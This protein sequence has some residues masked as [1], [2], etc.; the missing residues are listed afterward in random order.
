[1][2]NRS[3]RPPLVLLH[4][5]G[6]SPMA[7]EDVVPP[8]YA[9]RRLLTPW[10]PG[11]RPIDREILPLPEAAAALD[12]QLFLEGF[13]EV[14]ICAVSWGAMVALQLAADFPARVRR[15]IVIG[16]QVRP[17][18]VAIW[19]QRQAVRLVPASRLADDGV[20]KARLLDLLEVASR[21]DLRPVLSSITAATLVV[22]GSRDRVGAPAARLLA[23]TL[24]HARLV[25][26][27]GGGP[28]LN[29]QAPA[30]VV[31]LVRSHL[32]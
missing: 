1:M 13:E 18:R 14:D 29:T 30:T 24:P 3:A 5:L 8:L 19:A 21:A 17:P 27:P 2:V 7:W 15:L 25:I 26:M 31:E 22:V 10:V 11:T 4:G 9:E 16:A 23:D 12:Q 32:G 28:E 20:A 6:Q